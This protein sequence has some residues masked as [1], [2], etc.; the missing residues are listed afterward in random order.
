VINAGFFFDT[1]T[2]EAFSPRSNDHRILP[3]ATGHSQHCVIENCPQNEMKPKRNSFFVTVFFS[4][5][6]TPKQT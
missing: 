1:R 3:D 4:Q 2:G 5:N 6:K